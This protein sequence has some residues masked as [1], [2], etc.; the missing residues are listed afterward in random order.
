LREAVIV[1]GEV[2]IVPEGT[3][4]PNAKKIDDQRVWK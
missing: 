3:V 2:E 4:P 1:R